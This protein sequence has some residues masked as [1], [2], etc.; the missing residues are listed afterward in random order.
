MM[1]KR[2]CLALLCAAPF[3]IFSERR[4]AHAQSVPVID[5]Y[6]DFN[7]GA[8][9]PTE[10]THGKTESKL[11]WNDGSWWGVLW[12]PATNRYDIYRFEAAAQ[13]WLATNAA[14]D[15]RSESRADALWDGQRLYLASHYYATNPGPATAASASK[16]YRY[17]YNAAAKQYSLDAGF[18]VEVNSSKCETLTLDKDS[19]GKLWITW[20]EKNKVMI[21]RTLGN[22]LTWGAPFALPVQGN[23]TDPDDISGLVAFGSKVPADRDGNKIGVMWS[24]QNDS[25]TYFAVHRDGDADE[26]WQPR[27]IVLAGVGLG[28]ATEDIFNLKASRDPASEGDLY[29]AAVTN[30]SGSSA[31]SI[32]VLRRSS[33]GIWSRHVFATSNWNHTRPLLLLNEENQRLYVFARSTDT[34]RGNIYMKSASL[35]DLAFPTGRGTP[36]LRSASDINI[37]NPTAT[38]QGVNATTGILVLAADKDSRYYLHNHIVLINRAP[39]IASFIP[40]SGSVGAEITITGSNFTGATK[41]MFNSAGGTASFTIDSDTQLRASV[42]SG[43][44]SGKI[45]IVNAFDAGSSAADF[46]VTAPPTISSFAPADGPVGT[47]V[48]ILGANFLGTTNVA[49][50]GTAVAHFTVDSNTQ[51]RAAVPAGANTG[52]ISVANAEGTGFSENIFTVTSPPV[53]ASFSPI[54]AVAGTEITIAGHNFSGATN[55]SFNGKSTTFTLNDDT[56][57]RAKV[58]AGAATGPI[59]IANS[60]GAATSA[61]SFIVQHTLTLSY[62]GSGNVKLNPEG[63]V[64][65]EG[66]AVTLTAIPLPGAEFHN[67]DGD[68]EGTNPTAT[69]TMDAD[70]RVTAKFRD[71]GRYTVTL[72]IAGA[73]N[74]A[75]DPPGG[76]YYEGTLVTLTATPEPGQVFSGYSGD[77]KGW[78]TVDTMRVDSNKNLTAVFSPLPAPR[79]PDGI[80]TSAAEIKNLPTS[81]L[82]WENLKAGADEPIGAPN[83]SDLEDPV[84][85]RVLAKALVYARTGDETYR[86]AVIA[87]CMDA[88]GTEENGETLAF[89]RELLAYVLAADLVGL[90]ENQDEK[91]RQWL[92]KVL[93]ENLKGLTLRSSHETR[94][95]NWGTHCGATRAAI[96][97]YLGDATELERTARIFKGWLGD[98]NSYADFNFESNDLSWHANPNAPVGINPLGATIQGRSVDGV[99]PDDQRRSGPFRWPPPKENYVYGALQGALMH[100]IILYRAGYEVWHWE[101]QALLRAMKWLYNE[102]NY[103]AAGDDKWL[104]HIINYFYGTAGFSAPFPAGAGKNSGWTDWLYGSKYALTVRDE[105]GAIMIHALGRRND[106]LTVMNLQ[107]LPEAGYL[108]TGWSGDLQGVKNPETLVMDADKEVIANFVKAGPYTVTVNTAGSGAVSLNPPGGVYYG[109]SVVTLTANAS[110]GFKFTDWSGDLSGSTNP[111]DLT[112]TS[113]RSIT[114]TFKAVY[115]LAVEVV[116][117]GKVALDPANGPYEIGTVVTLTALPD[118]GYQFVE[119]RGDLASQGATNPTTITMSDHRRVQAVFAAIRVSHEETKTGGAT[120]SAL[121]TTAA[122]LSGANGRLYLAAITT[123]PYAKASAVTGLDL[124]WTFVKAQCSGRNNIGIELWMAQGIPQMRDD[125]AVTANLASAPYNAA[126]VV[127]RYAGAATKPLGDIVSGNTRGIDGGCSDGLDNSSYSFNVTAAMNGAVVYS[128]A[129]MRNKTHTPGTGYLERVEI[130]QGSGSSAAAMTVEDKVFPAAGSATVN[131]TFNGNTDWAMIAVVIKPQANGSPGDFDN[132]STGAAGAPAAFQLYPN[133]PN[134]FN[135]Q[136]KIEYYLPSEMSVRLFIYNLYGQKIRTLVNGVQSAGR[137]LVQWNGTDDG[138]AT[139]GS[140]IYLVQLEAGTERLTRRLILLK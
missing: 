21:N 50:N 99:L 95:N 9:G 62:V 132:D 34:G 91:F 85:V 116:S 8:A 41:V 92:R 127:S 124:N 43:A 25:T 7:F 57:L 44:T 3:V 33:L 38:K 5:G 35:S 82:S 19:T 73:G 45:T 77:F 120:S 123:R 94:P 52:K 66:T 83:L 10:P 122:S 100:A 113:H 81:G 75:L 86:E 130:K 97:R 2:W 64:Y 67:W 76:V 16:L 137:N 103:P 108:F 140:G 40:A 84:N 17:S 98:R 139:V 68:L 65:D 107:A 134:P 31:A 32:F 49:F 14:M 46:L 136:T 126:I 63:G 26:S 93:T 6:R 36:I 37:T 39:K 24:N 79:N 114:A 13:N 78:M 129:G 112:I 27:E 47:P 104:P 12:N 51:L 4:Q 102:A 115:N 60:A 87:I 71:L 118:T 135:L 110:P 42:P 74:V 18:P 128:A 53:I 109:G 23:D 72:N 70:K 105:N 11:W 55:V 29:A 30:L 80:W 58:P 1:P 56:Q 89:G 88:M 15:T 61:T 22:D 90:P 20:V 59:S 101:N 28:R 69:I 54:R 138:D 111:V 125:G 133:Y 96:A 117:S 106:S 48:T 121:V 119:W 131:G